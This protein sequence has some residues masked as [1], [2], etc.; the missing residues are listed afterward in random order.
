MTDACRAVNGIVHIASSS[1]P[2][3]TKTITKILNK[4]S[5]FKHLLNAANSQLLSSVTKQWTK[6]MSRTIFAP[7]NSA[8]DK[9]PINVSE[10]LLRPEN[11]KYLALFVY[12]HISWPAQFSCSLSQAPML[13][14]FTRYRLRVQV[15]NGVILISDKKIPL[16]EVDIAA[17]NGVI[18]AIPEVIVPPSRISFSRVCPDERW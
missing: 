13:H 2:Q 4:F 8:F 18:H 16:E 3:A 5:T 7:T 17:S 15:E 10:C 14:T 11:S 9:L 12:I 6:G 1:L